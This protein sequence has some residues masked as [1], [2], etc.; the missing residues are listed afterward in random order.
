ME[1]ELPQPSAS[2][3]K[4]LGLFEKLHRSQTFLENIEATLEPNLHLDRF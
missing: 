3:I 2:E 1:F 4:L